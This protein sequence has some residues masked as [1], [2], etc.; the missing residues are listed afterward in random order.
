MKGEKEG[1]EE[2]VKR[3]KGEGMEE[4]KK[5]RHKSSRSVQFDIVASVHM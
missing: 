4:G 1:N 3:R 2:G 5:R